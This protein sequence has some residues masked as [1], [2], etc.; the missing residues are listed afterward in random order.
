MI[1]G[2][3]RNKRSIEILLLNPSSSFWHLEWNLYDTYVRTFFDFS[4]VGSWGGFE[5]GTGL[6]FGWWNRICESSTS[7]RTRGNTAR[8]KKHLHSYIFY[9]SSSSVFSLSFPFGHIF[10][11]LPHLSCSIYLPFLSSL[12]LLST[13]NLIFFFFHTFLFFPSSLL[14][15]SLS[16]LW[17]YLSFLLSSYQSSV[18][19]LTFLTD[20][21]S[22]CP[23]SD[24]SYWPSLCTNP[25]GR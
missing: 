25:I 3:N 9:V 16:S 11:S 20:L 6:H 21:L 4:L 19:F 7:S 18:L 14:S 13:S 12:F 15:F 1:N 23:I 17:S 10:F 22:L 24:L 5:V 8:M 2:L